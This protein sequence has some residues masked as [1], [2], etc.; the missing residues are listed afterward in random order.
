MKPGTYLNIVDHAPVLA[1]GD[2]TVEI[3]LERLQCK[4]CDPA[5]AWAIIEASRK[6]CM[7]MLAAAGCPT[8]PL[9][10]ITAPI[11][12]KPRST[13]MLRA[14]VTGEAAQALTAIL[15]STYS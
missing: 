11:P 2:D 10:I 9:Q 7:T 3:E 1:W 14:T 12:L 8:A 5:T 4:E 6:E 15:V 13:L